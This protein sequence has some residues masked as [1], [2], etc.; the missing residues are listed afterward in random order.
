MTPRAPTLGAYGAGVMTLLLWAGAFLAI[1]AGVRHTEPAALAA[2]RFLFAGLVSVGWILFG[3]RERPKW[4]DVPRIAVCGLLGIAIYNGLLGAGEQGVGAGLA[5]F[6]ISTQAVFAALGAWW[7]EG[8]RLHRRLLLGGVVAA[9][10]IAIMGAAGE[11]G[12]STAGILLILA[13]AACSGFFFVLQR[14]LIARLGPMTSAAAVMAAGGLWLLPWAPAGITAMAADRTA[15][16]AILYLALGSSVCGYAFWMVAL[17]RLGATRAALLLY[18]MA[19]LTALLE[20]A[21]GEAEFALPTLAG[22]I[23]ALVGIG[24]AARPHR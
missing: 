15:R 19:P 5:S 4:R 17:D 16:T 3:A 21:I 24:V 11:G 9:S 1:R 7:L 6:V 2:A 10:G 12:G 8:A 18:L 20:I 13:A 14:P 23:L 22:A